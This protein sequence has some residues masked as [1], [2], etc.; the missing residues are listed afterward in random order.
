MRTKVTLIVILAT[1]L[2]AVIGGVIFHYLEQRYETELTPQ[3]LS[4]LSRFTSKYVGLLVQVAYRYKR[5]ITYDNTSTS[6]YV[7][8]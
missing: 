6:K 7:P 4:E 5:V 8:I 1:L 2:Y 3:V